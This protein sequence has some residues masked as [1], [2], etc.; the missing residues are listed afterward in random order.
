MFDASIS[1]R[2]NLWPDEETEE[3][4]RQKIPL[5]RFATREEVARHSLYLLSPAAEYITGVL[6]YVLHGAGEGATTV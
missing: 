4:I 2:A 6:G 1:A 3:R 5:G